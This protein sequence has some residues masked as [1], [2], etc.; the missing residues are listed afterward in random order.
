SARHAQALLGLQARRRIAPRY[1]HHAQVLAVELQRGE[2]AAPD[3]AGVECV[4]AV[5]DEQPQRRPVAAGDPE[6]ALRAA[7]NLVPGVEPGRLAAGR[8][9]LVER[10]TP[11]WRAV[12][13]PGEHVDDRA[14]AILAREL[15]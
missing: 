11:A 3:R 4:H 9:L 15:G 7:R 8:A 12:A 10:D 2:L 6:V 1:L 13:H 5:A 14:V